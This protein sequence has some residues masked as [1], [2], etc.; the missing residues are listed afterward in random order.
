MPPP[1]YQEYGVNEILNIKSVSGSPVYGDGQ[2]D[3]TANINKILSETKD[4][5]VIY[6]PAGTY[7][8][9]DTIHVPSG[10]RIIGDAFASTI[11][12][13]GTKFQD[14]GSV[15][16]MIRMGYPGDTGVTQISDIVFTV[17]DILP[18]CQLVSLL[19]SKYQLWK[20]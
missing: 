15:R 2:T 3:D 8:V 16:I 18:G 5:K 17:G 4:C 20:Y 10:T 9:T 19:L 11:S 6:F 1:T 12:A 7:I 13:V 14:P